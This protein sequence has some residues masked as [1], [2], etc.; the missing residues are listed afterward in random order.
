MRP[1]PCCKRTRP[2]SA[3]P[4]R[5][6]TT[7][8]SPGG[9]GDLPHTRKIFPNFP[10]QL[11]LLLKALALQSPHFRQNAFTLLSASILQ[12]RQ[13]LLALREKL[14]ALPVELPH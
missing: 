9:P 5:V 4:Q 13:L 6:L 10:R 3:A 11:A 2:A 1:P 12:T 14:F 7:G 8:T